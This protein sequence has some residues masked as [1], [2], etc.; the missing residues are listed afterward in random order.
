MAL[1]LHWLDLLIIGVYFVG[2][3]SLGMWLARRDANASEDEYFVAGRSF[4]WFAIGASLFASNISSEHL[5]GLSADGFRS[6]LAVG[7]YEWGAAIVLVILA[8]VFVP[9]YVGS[10]VRTMP[11]FLERRFGAGARI[12]LSLV[13]ILA[14]VL[15]RISVALYAGSV[16]MQELFGIGMWTAIVVLAVTTVFYT[17]AGGLKAVVY[18]DAVQAVVLLGG[19]IALTWIALSR[20]GGWEGLVASVE[21][22]AFDM[23]RPADDPEMPWPGLL[24]G[25]PVLGVWYWCTDQVIVQRVLGAKDV[26]NARMGAVFAAFLKILPVFLFVLPGLCGRVLF[27]ELTDAEAVFPTMLRELLPVGVTGLVAAGLIA[28]LMSS[29]DSTLNSTGTLVSLDFYERYRPGATQ[30][31]VVAVGRITT[32]AVMLFGMAW[33][34]VVERAESLFQYLQQV[35]AAISPPIA[36]AFLIG[37]FWRRANHT[38]VMAAL[39]GGLGVGILLMVF[40]PFPFLISA[41][42]TFAISVLLLVGGSLT[43]APPRPEQVEGLTWGSA[44]QV[45]SGLSD[46]QRRHF[47]VLATALVVIMIGLWTAFGMPELWATGSAA[48]VPR[49]TA[50]E[51]E[52]EGEETLQFAIREGRIRNHFYRRGPVAAH[53]LTTSGTEPRIVVAFPAG[54]SGTALWLEEVSEPVELEVEGELRGLVRDDGMRGVAANIVARGTDRLRVR[55]PVLGSV[56][57]IRDYMNLGELPEGFE[58]EVAVDAEAV[59]ARDSA[60]GDARYELRIRPAEGTEVVRADGGAVEIRGEGPLRFELVATGDE[61]PLTP[62][63]LSRLLN[64]SADDD[65]NARNALA[66]LT[67]EEK[68][69]AGSWRFLTYF[70]R[71]TLLSVRLLM[72]ALT[73]D[74]VEAGL[75][76]VIERVGPRG[77]VAH[78]EDIGEFP[79]FLGEEAPAYDYKMVD[80]DFML[81]PV[82]LRYLF[83]DPRGQERAAAF[84]ARRTSDGTSYADVLRRNL[85]MVLERARPYAESPG[86]E[87]L[88]RLNEGLN[89]G[90]WRDSE[91]GLGGGR[92]PFNVNA[93]LVPAALDAA[94]KLYAHPAMGED[95]E[96]AAEA[97]RL[98]EAWSD[99]ARHFRVEL[100]AEA[101]VA[102]VR[103][104]AEEAGVPADE[105]VGAVESL[106]GPVIF[107]GL[108]LDGE[109]EPL[110]VLH[111]DDGF[112]LLFTN[113]ELEEL[114]R[115]AWRVASPFPAGL[116]TPVG[117]VVANAAY[118]EDPQ[119]R[120]TFTREHYHGAVIW[121]WQQALMAQGLARQLRR[122]DLDAPTRAALE[123]AQTALWEVITAA[124]EMRTS[125]LWSWD[126]NAG[127]GWQLVPFGQGGGHHS[128]SNAAQLWSTVYLAVQPP[129]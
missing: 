16:V 96:R 23:I 70:G 25:I 13:T 129:E 43:T 24:L 22:E 111:S 64:D 92:V 37:V 54:N 65:G 71:D 117:M 93:A 58:H 77:A 17:A 95:A 113:P 14:N 1:T 38:G 123:A 99:A 98:A 86:T 103:G 67:Y 61:E 5:I 29:I 89:V 27:P 90:E 56:R 2:V 59:W 18:T 55:Q 33:V 32:V 119:V 126:W 30:K 104:Y 20:V 82:A 84:L 4:G 73:P 85:D 10:R 115:I 102:R 36:A 31:Q 48:A 19:T 11:E 79:A 105:A 47:R 100:S 80:D 101:A 42:V 28:A 60:D 116:R 45:L 83:E 21:P 110:A 108:A 39:L 9:F 69:L 120:A 44:K 8:T 107:G 6:G 87:T 78:E 51:R 50:G 112:V 94:A 128:E 72:P 52:P 35:N 124:N 53:L 91:E 76:S 121:S 62:I 12:Y 41:A 49:E 75:G 57:V 97:R 88:I 114:R 7:N 3:L 81:G 74:A 15:V 106:G 66:F 34:L 109:G 63:P 68:M 26:Q 40:E 125:E 118:A 46:A 122:D 127:D